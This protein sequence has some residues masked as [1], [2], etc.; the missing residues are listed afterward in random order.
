MTYDMK[1]LYRGIPSVYIC[2]IYICTYVYL[3]NYICIFYLEF[4]VSPTTVI[5]FPGENSTVFL[6]KVNPSIIVVSWEVN[7]MSFR[8][9][10]LVDGDLPGH[11]SSGSNITVSIP[12]NGTKYVCVIPA[13]PPAL[14][15][16]SDPAFLYIAGKFAYNCMYMHMYATICT[17]ICMYIH[18]C[19]HIHKCYHILV[20]KVFQEEICTRII[21]QH[22]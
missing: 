2:S 17:Y 14:P 8:L 10:E 15:I 22:Y 5:L 12:V 6:C 1:I 3:Y 19:I 20:V 9:D 13:T 16:L 11:N 21:L 4:V 18:N 7:G